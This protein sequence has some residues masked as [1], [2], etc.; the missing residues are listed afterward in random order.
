MFGSQIKT[1]CSLFLGYAISEYFFSHKLLRLFNLGF[2][3]VLSEQIFQ[4]IFQG[5]FFLITRLGYQ[6]DFFIYSHFF[7]PFSFLPLYLFRCE[8]CAVMVAVMKCKYFFF[9]FACCRMLFLNLFLLNFFSLCFRVVVIIMIMTNMTMT[10]S[11]F[12]DI[13]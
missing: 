12:L 8:K 10:S 1:L 9:L 4:F 2:Q 7:L 3:S 6:L 13:T 11:L 5:L